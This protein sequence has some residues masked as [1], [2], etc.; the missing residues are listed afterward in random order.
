MRATTVVAG[1]LLTSG[2]AHA[3]GEAVSGFPKWEERVMHEWS[4]ARGAIR[5]S[6]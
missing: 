5:R 6:R 1:I 4:N 2:L 3:N